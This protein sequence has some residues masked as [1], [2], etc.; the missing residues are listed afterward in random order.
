M[1]ARTPVVMGKSVLLFGHVK[2]RHD[3]TQTSAVEPVPSTCTLVRKTWE[4]K[5]SANMWN[6]RSEG[7]PTLK[8]VS[9]GT[10]KACCHT[11]FMC[12]KVP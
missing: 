4:N 5:A 2:G 11:S 12:G 6:A 10:W 1:R 8:Y 7:Q 9:S 3:S